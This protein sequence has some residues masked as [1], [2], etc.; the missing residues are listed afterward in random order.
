MRLDLPESVHHADTLIA[1]A[2]G[3][4]LATIGGFVATLLETRV[5][6][7]ERQRTAALTFGEV[8]ASLRVILAAADDAHAVGDPFGPLT[9]R[10]L[11][12]ARREVDAFERNRVAL[13]DL[14]EAEV[15]LA[16]QALMIRIALGLDGVIETKGAADRERAYGYLTSLV[17]G[18][19][20]LVTRLVPLAGQPITP[21]LELDH[22]PQ[23]RTGAAGGLDQPAATP[24]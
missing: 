8:L 23:G 21:Y 14:R 2:L 20:P 15:R 12:A 9:V 4:V 6:R 22:N 3:A 13:S 16:V 19:N 18:I 5:H 1:V 10:L 11:R 24:P 17:P 7:R